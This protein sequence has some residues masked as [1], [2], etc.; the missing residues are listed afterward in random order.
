MYYIRSDGNLLLTVFQVVSHFGSTGRE[1][2]LPISGG[3]PGPLS[4][5]RPGDDGLQPSGLPWSRLET[6][7]RTCGASGACN[8]QPRWEIQ[9][10]P[11]AD[12]SEV[13][14]LS[15]CLQAMLPSWF[16]LKRPLWGYVGLALKRFCLF[17]SEKV[18]EMFKL[19]LL[20]HLISNKKY[21]NI[22]KYYTIAVAMFV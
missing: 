20:K 1:P 8:C 11:S 10:E 6:P 3:A 18:L 16:L 22:N 5:P 19:K 4:G 21:P 17:R 13:I 14:S 7:R 2:P 12:Y 15:R 9:E